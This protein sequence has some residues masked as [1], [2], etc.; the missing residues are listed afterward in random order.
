MWLGF[1]HIFVL[2][3]ETFQFQVNEKIFNSNLKVAQELPPKEVGY[4]KIV[5]AVGMNP[6]FKYVSKKFDNKLWRFCMS[7]G[8]DFFSFL[9][10]W[11]LS[12]LKKYIMNNWDQWK[13]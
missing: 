10:V 12:S 8:F 4:W 1:I 3:D 2:T 6:E 11:T 9:T 13:N 7:S 5:L